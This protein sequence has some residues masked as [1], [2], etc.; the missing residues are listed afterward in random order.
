MF[1]QCLNVFIY[2]LNFFSGKNTDSPSY[3]KI[4]DNGT[5]QF[6]KVMKED[7]GSYV[8]EVDNGVGIPLKKMVQLVVY[9]TNVHGF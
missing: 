5:L 4:L 7:D 3:E 2:F 1:S 9:G 8:C 6:K